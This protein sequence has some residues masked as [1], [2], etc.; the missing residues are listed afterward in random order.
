MCGTT[1]AGVVLMTCRPP[2][3][4]GLDWNANLVRFFYHCDPEGKFHDQPIDI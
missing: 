4:T 1:V 2:A 3:T